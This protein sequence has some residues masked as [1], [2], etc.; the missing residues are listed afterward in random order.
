VK[1]AASILRLA[2]RIAMLA[3]V[4][5]VLALVSIQFEGICAKNVAMAR[6]VGASRAEI[7]A[8]ERRE[9]EQQRTLRRLATPDGAIPEIHAKLNL[10]GPHEEIF[11]V[12]GLT[13]R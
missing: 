5:C 7:A 12:R 13:D 4:S 6:E 8:L 11:Y 2:G 3:I 9:R 1:R 10:V